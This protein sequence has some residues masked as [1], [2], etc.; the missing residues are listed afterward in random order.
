MANVNTDKLLENN[1]LYASGQQV[2]NFSAAGSPSK[3]AFNKSS[4]NASMPHRVWWI[5]MISLVLSK[6]CEIIKQRIASSVITPPAFRIIWASPV[7]KAQLGCQ[8][9][10]FQSDESSLDSNDRSRCL[11]SAW[12]YLR[13]WYW[14]AWRSELPG[15]NGYFWLMVVP[16]T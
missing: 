15:A 6:W 8:A 16:I 5:N 10:D 13:C 11:D 3:P 9:L 14:K 1:K 12:I 7:C 4:V 2:H